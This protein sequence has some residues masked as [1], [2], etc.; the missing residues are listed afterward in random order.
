M[1]CF[2]N[3]VDEPYTFNFITFVF[4]TLKM[5]IFIVLLMELVNAKL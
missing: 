1:L 5:W 3:D 2:I 4:E